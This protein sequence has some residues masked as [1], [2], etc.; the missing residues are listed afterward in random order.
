MK[1]YLTDSLDARL[2]NLPMPA[3][4]TLRQVSIEHVR[5]T[6]D[7]GAH[8][9]FHDQEMA[10]S[11]MDVLNRRITPLYRQANITHG[12]QLLLATRVG[13]TDSAQCRPRLMFFEVRIAR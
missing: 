12:D 2:S 9:L 3:A 6:V 5:K 10:A 7:H 4:I 1:V 11:I 8:G 13:E